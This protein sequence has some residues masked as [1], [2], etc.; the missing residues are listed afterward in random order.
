[1][2]AGLL[3]A[4]CSEP[5]SPTPFPATGPTTAIPARFLFVNA[6]PGAPQLNFLINNVQTGA[7][8]GFGVA[9]AA[10]APS[11]TGNVQLRAR[12]TTGQIGGTL[13]ASDL[14][15]RAGATNNNNFS[16]V[17]GRNY[18]VFATDTTTRPRPTTPAGVTDPGGSRFLVVE[19]NLAVPAAGKAHVRFFHL[20]AGA[21]AVCV[22]V[23]GSPT[24]LFANRSYRSVSTGSGASLVNFANFTPV[25]AG[26]YAFEVRTGSATGS[27]AL[28]VPGVTLTAGKIYTIYANGLLRSTATP[29]NAGIVV[30]N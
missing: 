28:S 6:A 3:A 9:Q 7:A 16:A 26:T 11:Q 23:A 2:A 12:A 5:E 1:M 4:A 10:Y 17:S 22:N 18:T 20:A 8:A 27:V 14:I 24:S 19:D 29:L 25:D 13:G 15:F 30:H 21:P